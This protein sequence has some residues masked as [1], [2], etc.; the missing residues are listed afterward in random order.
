M[1]PPYVIGVHPNS[2]QNPHH[3][4]AHGGTDIN[5]PR[6]T[7]HILYGGIV[8][9]P[10]KHDKFKDDRSD[11]IQS[12]VALDYNA[13]FQNLMAYQV[14]NAQDDPYYVTLPPGRPSQTN[15]VL[16]V[17]VVLGVLLIAAIGIFIYW[18]KYYRKRPRSMGSNY[19]TNC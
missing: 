7:Q 13:P 14:I 8:G 11:Y 15:V 9:G 1:K 6:K 16:I 18:K 19:K 4:G 12:E 10:S 17:L 3:S 5:H 2:P